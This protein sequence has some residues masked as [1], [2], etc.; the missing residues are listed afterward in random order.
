VLA[1]NKTSA[2]LADKNTELAVRLKVAEEQLR[3]LREENQRLKALEQAHEQLKSELAQKSER[4]VL[5][6]EELKWLKAQYYGRSIQRLDGA[7]YN[8]D[9]QILFNEAEVLAA[10]EAADAAHAAR[11]TKVEA[12]ERKRSPD[13]GRKAIPEHFPR[14]VIEHDLSAEEKLCTKCAVP[15]PLR[16]IGEE[17][18]ECIASRPRRSASSSISAQRMCVRSAR[19]H[20][21]QRLPRR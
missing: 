2:A 8:P 20:R 9:Q 14:M 13:S 5:L 17:K 18:R 4:T 6:E 7:E 1:P 19:R 21:S 3:L 16:R 12:H 10:I 15:H 11:T